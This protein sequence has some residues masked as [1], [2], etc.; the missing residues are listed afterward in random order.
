MKYKE[1]LERYKNGLASEEEKLIIEQDIEKYEAIEQYLSDAMDDEFTDLTELPKVE[2]NTEETIKLKKSV[3]KRLHKV[4]YTS[5][6]SVIALLLV[7]F[8]IISPLVDSLYYNPSKVS[9]GEF[10][11]DIDFDVNVVTE[12]NMPGFT[13]GNVYVVKQG[14]GNYEINYSYRNIFTEEYYKANSIIKRGEIYTFNNEIFKKYFM[15]WDVQ[16]PN[17]E[18]KYIDEHKER[19]INH[20]KLLNPVSY[21]SVAISFENDLNMEELNNL[22][23]KYPD[24]EFIW[25]GM[26]TDSHNNE[27][28]DLIGIQLLSNNRIHLD[29]GVE[30]KYRAFS[31]LKW[32]TNPV[33]SGNSSLPLVAQAYELHYKSL[34]QYVIDRKDEVDIF[35]RRPWKNEFYK[36][37]LT[38]AEEYGVKTYGVLVFAEAQDLIELIEN[39]QIKLVEFNQALV[40]KK[41]IQ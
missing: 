14:F 23:L 27:T 18:Q 6:T 11:K 34:L 15:F 20:M 3:N 40:S 22:E 8:F 7:V 26:R 13:V 37:A 33:G 4:V 29:D 32:L 25:A 16:S 24:I 1:L 2:K 36:S 31:I 19:V 21:I 41:Y 5:V 10:D 17:R 38:Y 12:L 28:M 35:E 30:E 39:E 9:V